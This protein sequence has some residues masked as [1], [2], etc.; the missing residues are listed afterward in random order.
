MSRWAAKRDANEA[1]IVRVLEQVALVHRLDDWDLLVY[2]RGRL[3]M[4]DVKGAKGRP[5]T[6]Q[7]RLIRDGWPLTYVRTP[8][9]A[10]RVIDALR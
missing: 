9:E 10:L 8:D 4:L 6:A 2:Y 7:E 1:E 5:T 3:F